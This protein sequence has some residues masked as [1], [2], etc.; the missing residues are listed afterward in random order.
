[1]ILVLIILNINA[2]FVNNKPL[3]ENTYVP[4][5]KQWKGLCSLK[6]WL[7]ATV[8]KIDKY[9]LS[10]GKTRHY[11]FH[12]KFYCRLKSNKRVMALVVVMRISM[13]NKAHDI[14]FDTDTHTIGVDKRCTACILQVATD[15]IGELRKCKKTIK[16]FGEPKPVTSRQIHCSGN[17]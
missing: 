1:M 10:C 8:N 11:H 15:F 12:T 6:M 7:H 17:G 5:S 2:L 14:T 16:V 9:I 4:K 13:S 3:Y